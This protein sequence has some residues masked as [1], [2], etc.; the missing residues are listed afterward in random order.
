MV[1]WGLGVQRRWQ[2]SRGGAGVAL[3]A[4]SRWGGA[5]WRC[6]CQVPALAR[7]LGEAAPLMG[8]KRVRRLLMLR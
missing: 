5:E 2:G 8:N 3:G 4:R 7:L 6:T 1:A